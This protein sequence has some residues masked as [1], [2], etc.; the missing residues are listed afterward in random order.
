MSLVL[1]L[2]VQLFTVRI[3]TVFGGF[4]SLSLIEHCLTHYPQECVS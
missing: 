2:V 3:D 1:K 4:T